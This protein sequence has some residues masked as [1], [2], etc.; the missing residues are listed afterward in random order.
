[1]NDVAMFFGWVG[2]VIIAVGFGGITVWIVWGLIKRQWR[3][4]QQKWKD[5][6]Y[7]E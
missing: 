6:Q 5:S 1:M 2:L 7:S 4:F 3:K